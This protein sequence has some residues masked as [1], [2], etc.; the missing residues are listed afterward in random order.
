MPTRTPTP[1]QT[2]FTTRTAILV[3]TL[4][5]APLLLC[6]AALS[7]PPATD[8]R[9]RE[10]WF[11][12]ELAG[13]RAGF[14][15]EQV[16]PTGE[17][18]TVT[19]W[20]TFSL[21]RSG[22]TVTADI[23]T[24]VNQSAAGRTRM[25]WISRRLGDAAL[26]AL[27]ER[28]DLNTGETITTTYEGSKELSRKSG[29]PISEPFPLGPL[30]AEREL[31]AALSRGDRTITQ[32][33]FDPATGP[34]PLTTTRTVTDRTAYMTPSGESVPVFRCKATDDA[35]PGVSTD[36]LIDDQGR[37]VRTTTR[38][39]ELVLTISLA[40]EKTAR[41]PI[42]PPT[43]DAQPGTGTPT[44]AIPVQ[45]GLTSPRRLTS[46][47]YTLTSTQPPALDATSLPI[48][49]QQS[50]TKLDD[51]RIRINVLA[52]PPKAP[53]PAPETDLTNAAF[54]QPSAFIE[55]A[56]PDIRALVA[57]ASKGPLAAT[58]PLAR[59]RALRAL[60]YRTLSRSST[61]RPAPALGFATAAQALRAR[62]GDCTEHAVLLA[63]ALRADNIP[64]RVVAGVIASPTPTT[65]DAP[66]T[67]MNW[68]MWTQ[69]LV[70]VAGVKCWVD[71]DA[72]LPPP[73]I[74]DAAHVA[75]FAT[76][77]SDTRDLT[78]LASRLGTLKLTLEFSS[79]QPPSP[80]PPGQ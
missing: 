26:P 44:A 24:Q 79:T 68:H 39:G 17:D 11:T 16:K 34:S 23:Q 54:L 1:W 62:A 36:E 12:V 32:R 10:R 33:T 77:L 70:P 42:D 63:A 21:R 41:A 72:T 75:L 60:V 55:S 80:R 64:A 76:P 53:T 50:V 47:T 28:H 14:M 71:L 13:K 25:L 56:D 9:A 19:T 37:T 69:T 59:A 65:P 73:L 3:L 29:P 66:I 7:T 4:C 35:H 6:R 74:F 30:T 31:A 78:P 15:R 49:A 38:L 5:L 51:Q 8:P 18:L 43:L 58:E 48:S 61:A 27:V 22:Q 57:S 46:A 67:A 45:P 20:T 2:T 40:D 52:L